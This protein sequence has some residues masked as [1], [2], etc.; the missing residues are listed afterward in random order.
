MTEQVKNLASL[1]GNSSKAKRI[2]MMRGAH[3]TL[4]TDP[5]PVFLFSTLDFRL[6]NASDNRPRS[7]CLRR[8]RR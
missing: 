7:D 1:D 3:Q 6:N 8:V 4:S 2:F 5:L